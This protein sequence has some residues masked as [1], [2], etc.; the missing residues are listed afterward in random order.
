MA[1]DNYYLSMSIPG[2]SSAKNNSVDTGDNEPEDAK[3]TSSKRTDAEIETCT[4]HETYTSRLDPRLRPDGTLQ[5]G[6]SG[7]L[8]RTPLE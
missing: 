2:L 8:K 5:P 3:V 4:S 1:Y 6:A 7:K